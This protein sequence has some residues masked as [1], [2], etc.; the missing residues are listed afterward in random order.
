M[1]DGY[2]DDIADM[3]VL[4]GL[5]DSVLW[6]AYKEKAQN[7]YPVFIQARINVPY[8]YSDYKDTFEMHIDESGKEYLLFSRRYSTEQDGMKDYGVHSYEYSLGDYYN[9]MLPHLVRDESLDVYSSDGKKA[10]LKV[11]IDIENLLSI[12]TND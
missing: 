1:T 6:H 10:S 5:T 7:C 11:Y 4:Y 3:N 8:T 2:S 9:D 12:I